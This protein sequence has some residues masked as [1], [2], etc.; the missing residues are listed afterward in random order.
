MYSEQPD[1]NSG[2]TD[3]GSKESPER[4]EIAIGEPSPDREGEQDNERH[5]ASR[6]TEEQSHEETL[7]LGGRMFRDTRHDEYD[8]QRI[9]SDEKTS[10]IVL[11]R[12]H[13]SRNGKHRQNGTT[14]CQQPEDHRQQVVK[15]LA[16]NRLVQQ[17]FT[18]I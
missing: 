2:I 3:E 9:G 12:V 6:Y 1:G 5:P 17:R 8:Q 15:P 14:C 16:V 7:F 4:E 11:P 13:R 10:G 18:R